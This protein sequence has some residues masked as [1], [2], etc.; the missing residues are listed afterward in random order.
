M[1]MHLKYTNSLKLGLF[2]IRV[3]LDVGSTGMYSTSGSL[4][5]TGNG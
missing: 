5:L 4:I 1:R 3:G 2:W